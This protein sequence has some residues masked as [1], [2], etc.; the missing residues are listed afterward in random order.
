MSIPKKGSHIIMI[1]I[2]IDDLILMGSDPKI[3]NHVKNN[4]K[5]K[6]EMTD[7]RYL[8]YFLHL[9]VLKTKEGIFFPSI[10]ILVTFFISFTW[11]I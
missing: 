7:L 1:V 6:F 4:L 9:Q 2:Y 11:K 5:K 8:H 3:L 10:S